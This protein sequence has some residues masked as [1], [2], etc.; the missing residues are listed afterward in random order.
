MESNALLHRARSLRLWGLVAHWDD[1]A[2]QDWLPALITHEEEERQHR[3]LD[4]RVKAAKVG[5]FKP[6]AKFDW[7][8]PEKVD[9]LQIDEL[10]TLRFLEERANVV[11]AGANGLGKSMLAKNLVH[12]AALKGHSS[13]FVSASELLNDLAEPDSA[14]E[15]QRRL[16]RYCNTALLAIDEVGYL[17]Y[18]SRH[19]DLLFE[20]ITKC[21]EKS[22]III[23]TNKAFN[24]WNQIFTNASC[25]STLIDRLVHHCEIV[26]F[27][28]RSYREKEA[29]ERTAKVRA[30]RDRKRKEN[31]RKK[32]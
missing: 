10:F 31:R 19:A 14:S 6:M 24:E 29:R 15:R 11:I 16:R 23:T 7:T 3:T 21:Y 25:V 22:S 12:H 5:P 28:G 20:V 13:R 17:S 30:E 18:D 1:Y 8:W 26:V 9:R 27:E 32:Q 2:A 4:A